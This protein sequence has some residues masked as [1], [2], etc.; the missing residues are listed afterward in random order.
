MRTHTAEDRRELL[1]LN[2]YNWTHGRAAGIRQILSHAEDLEARGRLDGWPAEKQFK[3]LIET[4]RL[5]MEN[6]GKDARRAYN[7]LLEAKGLNP[8]IQ[9]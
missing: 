8:G 5:T 1:A 3:T 6:A 4:I 9:D 2:E 7:E